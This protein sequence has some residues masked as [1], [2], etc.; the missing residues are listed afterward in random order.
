MGS[1]EVLLTRSL[2]SVLFALVSVPVLDPAWSRAV[3]LDA[4][5][6]DA[7]SRRFAPR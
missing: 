5:R 6:D 1:A 4:H 3:W 7:P 2:V